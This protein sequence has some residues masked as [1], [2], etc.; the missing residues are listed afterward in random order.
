[1]PRPTKSF[2]A[3][4]KSVLD[5]SKLAKV[6]EGAELLFWRL[7]TGTDGWGCF[8]GR[9]GWIL[10]HLLTARLDNGELDVGQVEERIQELESASLVHRYEVEGETFLQ[11]VDYRDPT[12]PERRYEDYPAPPGECRDVIAQKWD[13]ARVAAKEAK[14]KR[15]A[16]AKTDAPGQLRIDGAECPQ[17]VP[18]SGTSRPPLDPRPKN[19]NPPH[20]PPAGGGG[21]VGSK[22][23]RK[24]RA[25]PGEGW[26]GWLPEELDTSRFRD[27]W[28]RFRVFLSEQSYRLPGRE[29]TLANFERMARW[30]PIKAIEAIENA[31]ASGSYMLKEPVRLRGALPDPK[32]PN[33][34]PG[35]LMSI[36]AR[37]V[38]AKSVKLTPE[39]A[40]ENERTAARQLEE[41][42]AIRDALKHGQVPG[43]YRRRA[44]RESA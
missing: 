6:S 36:K 32:S 9:A 31:I 30:G 10:G 1:M 43:Q 39:E 14:P 40:A 11:I 24:K 28:E 8:H 44:D 4:Y 35:P 13:S 19:P 20:S 2:Q 22:E 7:L 27:G 42:L 37:P 25:K 26:E 18:S 33:R 41:V 38:A 12:E 3:V 15:Q 29:Q 34:G 17:D 16:K 21:K 23:P 5:S